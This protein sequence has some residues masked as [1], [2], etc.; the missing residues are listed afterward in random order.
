MPNLGGEQSMISL[1]GTSV[2]QLADI[3][4]GSDE[5]NS[6]AISGQSSI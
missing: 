5:E 2:T 6:V 1:Y 4:K 3:L